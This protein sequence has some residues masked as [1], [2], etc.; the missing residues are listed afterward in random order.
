MGFTGYVADTA[1]AIRALD[2]LV[3]AS[4]QPEPFGRVIAE[5]MA[6]GRAV[7]C[8]AA[9][10]A[11]ELIVDGQD[12]LAHPPGDD[13]A[14]A[15]RM[16]K[17]VRDPELRARLGRAARITAELR[18]ERRRLAEEVIPLYQRLR[19]DPAPRSRKRV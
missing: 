6:C 17:L 1:S 13:A 2:I 11:A 18:F 3:H 12:A 19:G 16:P 15:E 14:L 9:G 4:T 5:G 8:S 10:G 7:I